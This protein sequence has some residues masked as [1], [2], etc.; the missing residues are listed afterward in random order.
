[1]GHP[2][3]RRH[4]RRRSAFQGLKMYVAAG[5]LVRK[6]TSVPVQSGRDS[7]LKRT[8]LV[9]SRSTAIGDSG[10]RPRTSRSCVGVSVFQNPPRLN[11]DRTR[12]PRNRG[13]VVTC[14]YCRAQAPTAKCRCASVGVRANPTGIDG[15]R[16]L[17]LGSLAV[18]GTSCS[19]NTAV[20]APALTPA[21]DS[22]PPGVVP[23]WH[24]RRHVR[25]PIG[26]VP[27]GTRSGKGRE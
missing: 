8:S 3:S 25:A 1:M 14:P 27:T 2:S 17:P 15:E 21:W 18:P 12:E 26:P 4:S 10:Q 19:S 16:S 9:W 24:H 6:V 11:L 7:P 20:P 13:A 22:P 5:P 23:S